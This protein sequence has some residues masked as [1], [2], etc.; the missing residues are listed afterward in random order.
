MVFTIASFTWHAIKHDLSV[1]GDY[2]A[3]AE[4]SLTPYVSAFQPKTG[5]WNQYCH[6][7][8][9]ALHRW[10]AKTM[11][12]PRRGYIDAKTNFSSL[13]IFSNPSTDL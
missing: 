6:Y 4:K 13:T 3:N 2:S 1:F 9:R 10:P 7:R 11:E 12:A 5:V 8:F